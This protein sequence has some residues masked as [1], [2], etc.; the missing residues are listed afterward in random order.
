MEPIQGEGG[1]VVPPDG[2]LQGVR[3]LCDRYGI[4][5]IVDEVQTGIGRTGKWWGVNHW[6]VLPDVVCAA[7]GIASGMPLSATIARKEIMSEWAPGAHASTFGGNPVSCAAA[8]ATF[9]LL[10]SELIDNAA[11]MG[12]YLEK[13][14]WDIAS[15]HPSIGDVRG[16]G[17]MMGVEFVRDRATRQRAPDI[18]DAVVNHAFEERLLLLGCGPNTIRI[19]PALTVEP[20]IIDKALIIFERAIARAEEDLL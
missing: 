12:A 13:K 6:N 9:D 1:Y 15:R 4:L 2:F 16:R 20:E 11:R 5:F 18:R 14:L 19:I 17:L 7:K 8:I 3:E 10:R